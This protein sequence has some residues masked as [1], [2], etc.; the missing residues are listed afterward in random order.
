MLPG[1]QSHAIN[2]IPVVINRM[3]PNETAISVIF[4]RVV[5]GLSSVPGFDAS[6]VL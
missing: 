4:A 3:S 2:R 5:P 6:T 1:S